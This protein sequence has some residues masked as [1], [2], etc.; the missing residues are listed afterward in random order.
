MPYAAMDQIT[1]AT[2]SATVQ[3]RTLSRPF[4]VGFGVLAAGMLALTII[5]ISA[6]L[7]YD[8]PHLRLSNDHV[9]LMVKTELTDEL[10]ASSIAFGDIPL[11]GRLVGI[12]TLGILQWGALVMIFLGARRLFRLYEQ[13]VVFAAANVEC[14]RQIGFWLILW[15][16]APAIGHQITLL[17]GVHDEGWLRASSMAGVILGG[18]LF[19]IARVMNLGREIELDRASIV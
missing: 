3:I 5:V 13:G 8:G 12:F 11:K 15:G 9:N 6:A 1:D 16:V 10:L 7:F 18:L 17:A 2:A 19:V 14:I 4:S